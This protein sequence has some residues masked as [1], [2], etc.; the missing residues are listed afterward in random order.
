[1]GK[2]MVRLNM[3]DARIEK[4]KIGDNVLL[5]VDTVEGKS[6]LQSVMVDRR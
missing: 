5:I 3:E 6:T 4:V 2:A 1:M